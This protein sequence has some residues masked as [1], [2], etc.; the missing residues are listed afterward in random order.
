MPEFFVLSVEDDWND[1]LFLKWALAK[2]GLRGS[3]QFVR[4]GAAAQDY[5]LGISPF[6]DRAKY[7]F[8]D[9]LLVDLK[10]PGI[11]GFQLLEWLRA[12][13]F[14]NRRLKAAVLTGSCRQE[15]LERGHGLGANF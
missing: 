2:A 9:L 5:L 12:Q 1:V 13:S 8:P 6:D 15:D 10:M 3:F 7:P 14:A 4:S 11:D